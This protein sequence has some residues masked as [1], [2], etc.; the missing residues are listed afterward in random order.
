MTD[1]QFRNAMFGG[2]NR[3][4]VLNFLTSS[5][6]KNNAELA[7]R[8]ERCEELEKDLERCREEIAALKEQLGQTAQER[9]EFKR[10]AEQLSIEIAR[11]S[12]VDQTRVAELGKKT[13]ELSTLRGEVGRL[14][15]LLTKLAPDAEAYAAIKERAAGVEL[16]AHRRAQN[17]EARARA[18]ADDLQSQMEQWM[19]Q[20]E[21]QYIQLRTEVEVSVEQANQQLQA[22]GDSLNRVNVLLEEQQTALKSVADSYAD[23]VRGEKEE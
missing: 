5:A 20:V 9:E 15:G 12:S 1:Y 2:F 14:S 17:V 21:Q 10:Q 13:E 18:M 6:E 22:A 19:A 16:E 8:Q 3:Q 23:S 11:V 4:D 7:A